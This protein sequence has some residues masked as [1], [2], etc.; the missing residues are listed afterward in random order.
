MKLLA[1]FVLLIGFNSFSQN[2]TILLKN[3]D[4]SLFSLNQGL[5]IIVEEGSCGLCFEKI[6][7]IKERVLQKSNV[8]VYV[9]FSSLNLPL[10]LR[11]SCINENKKYVKG[12]NM[13]YLFMGQSSVRT[14][15]E[16][17]NLKQ[18]SGSPF[19]IC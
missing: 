10:E 2:N 17:F 18:E 8:P 15:R 3:I 19:F 6:N 12:K 11:S 4:D 1:F 13:E 5:I 9:V 7:S 16:L 14:F